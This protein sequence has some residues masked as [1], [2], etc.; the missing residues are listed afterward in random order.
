MTNLAVALMALVLAT[1]TGDASANASGTNSGHSRYAETGLEQPWSL[2]IGADVM[3]S[4]GTPYIEL[5]YSGTRWKHWSAYLGSIHQTHAFLSPR[6]GAELYETWFSDRL[7]TGLGITLT[8]PDQTVGTA[9]R[10]QIRFGWRFNNGW[11]MDIVHESC[12][13]AASGTFLLRLI[14]HC[15]KKTHNAGYNFLTIRIPF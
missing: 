4:Q 10:Y 8:S 11:G 14:P 9:L 5:R 6:I 13:S 1:I 12:F 2:A 7:I 15:T 3:H